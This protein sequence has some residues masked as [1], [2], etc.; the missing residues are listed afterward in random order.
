[1]A[2][3]GDGA[4][5]EAAGD[6]AVDEAAGDEV[7]VFKFAFPVCGILNQSMVSVRNSIKSSTLSAADGF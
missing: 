4:V 2:G 7:V 6:G 3:A 5:D 1:L